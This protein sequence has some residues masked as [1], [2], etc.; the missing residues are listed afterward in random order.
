MNGAP[1]EPEAEFGWSAPDADD[2]GRGRAR[3]LQPACRVLERTRW[4][5]CMERR[6]VDWLH[7]LP[8]DGCL[9]TVR[10]LRTDRTACLSTVRAREPMSLAAGPCADS[11]IWTSGGENPAEVLGTLI[12]R[13]RK[14]QTC[15]ECAEPIRPGDR[16]EVVSGKWDGAWS[17]FKTCLPCKEIREAFCCEGWIYGTLW[18]DARESFF[19][20][21]TT[22]C[23]E[24][25]E[26][27]AAKEK[28]VSQ[29]NEWVREL[30]P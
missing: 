2:C 21:M 19:E 7:L 16:Y 26:T 10:I 5:Q 17:S 15:C 13:A 3:G 8:A 30:G 24:K 22:G 14:P 27:A 29:W 1:Y 6:K 4:Q 23:L 20:T 18:E 25:L 11:C 9:W 28:L 12:V